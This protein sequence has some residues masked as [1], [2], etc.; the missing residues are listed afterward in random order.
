MR[1]SVYNN[2][3]DFEYSGYYNSDLPYGS[4][5]SCFSVS[6]PIKGKP[7]TYLVRGVDEEGPF[8]IS[9]RYNDFYNFYNTLCIRWPG[10]YI[11]PIP[12]KKV[13]GNKDEKYLKERRIFLE[14]FIRVLGENEFI[15]NS[16]EFKIFSRHTGKLE[17]VFK[18]LPRLTSDLLLRRFQSC[19]DYTESPDNT[20]V[21][22][23]STEINEF[24]SFIRKAQNLLKELKERTKEMITAKEAMNTHYKN[25]TKMA[26]KYEDHNL[27]EY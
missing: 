11:P 26:T 5:A 1:Y 25:L 23:C 16:E 19:L 21:K 10:I 27:K 22:H 6:D 12:P 18:V 14:K 3:V 13:G 7:V 20:Q 4:E 24:S 17:K 15:V 8:E 2:T 9:R